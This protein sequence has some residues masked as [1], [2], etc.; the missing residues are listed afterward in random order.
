MAIQ[1][2]RGN[3]NDFDPTR[4]VAGE[5][6]VCL[7]NEYVYITISPGHVVQLGTLSA[8]QTALAQAQADVEKAEAWAKGTKDGTAVPSTDPAY[9][10]NAKYYSTDSEAWAKG[11]RNGTAVPS[12]DPTYHNNAKYFSE[13]SASV[14][15]TEQTHATST[16][17]GYQALTI[18]NTDYIIKGTAFMEDTKTM[19]TTEN[20]VFTFTHSYITS[21]SLIDV[22][23]SIF[24]ATPIDIS[25]TNGTCEVIFSA[26]EEEVNMSCIIYIK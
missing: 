7:D 3:Y 8:I 2:R 9:Q 6:A 23:P 24:G 25:V 11:T 15:V 26:V 10:N 18:G 5:F 12:T 16:V 22:Y 4:M 21:N 1:V 19:S 13:Q 20:N 14:S 17:L